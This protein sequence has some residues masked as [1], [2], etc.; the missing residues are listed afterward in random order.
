MLNPLLVLLMLT[1]P[2]QVRIL[3]RITGSLVGRFVSTNSTKRK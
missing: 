3:S 2:D 1:L